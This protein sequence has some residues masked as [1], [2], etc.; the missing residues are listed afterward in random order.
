MRKQRICCGP[1]QTNIWWTNILNKKTSSEEWKENL[2]M[3][4]RLFDELCER[5]RPYLTG[6]NT[7]MRD[8]LPVERKVAATLYYLADESRYRKIKSNFVA[9]IK[10]LIQIH[11][12][13]S[14]V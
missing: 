2:R 4:R 13:T 11:V 14:Y 8:V 9:I 3:D 10:Y 6:K 12:H 5:L 7:I 1:G